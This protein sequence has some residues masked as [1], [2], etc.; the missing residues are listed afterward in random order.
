[1]SK[2]RSAR[3]IYARGGLRSLLVASESHTRELFRQSVLSHGERRL[4]YLQHRRRYGDAAPCPGRLVHVDPSAIEYVLFPPLHRDHAV[5]RYDTHVL[6][7]EWDRSPIRDESWFST[8]MLTES[9][10]D[11]RHRFRLEE[12]AFYRALERGRDSYEAYL[13]AWQEQLSE[14]PKGRSTKYGDTEYVANHYDLYVDIDENGYKSGRELGRRL[15]YPEFYDVPV[16]IGRHGEFI[17]AGFGKH[18]IV[19]AQLLELDSIP[20]R[21]NVR[22]SRWQKR[23]NAAVRTGDGEFQRDLPAEHPDLRPLMATD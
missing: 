7:G 14:F 4:R 6:A 18:R 23:R 21:V 22:H 20:V 1:M 19:I 15:L 12:Y 10:V 2:L 11:R 16:Y 3:A 8:R 17:S 5:T 9:D 13:E